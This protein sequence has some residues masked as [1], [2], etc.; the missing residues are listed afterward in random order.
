VFVGPNGGGKSAFFD[1]IL[2]FSMVARGNIRQ[3]FSQFPYSF[4]A[5]KRHGAG[6]LERIGY[7]AVLSR[8]QNSPEALRYRVDYTQQGAAEAG[9]PNFQITNEVLEKLPSKAVLFDRNQ[10]PYSSPLKSAVK[11]LEDDRGI[12]AAVRTARL[13]GACSGRSTRIS[14]I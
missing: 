4:N 1:A 7:D 2:N 10:E 5:T 12:F 11:Y 3:A 14:E 6:K 13:S 9:Y 8:A